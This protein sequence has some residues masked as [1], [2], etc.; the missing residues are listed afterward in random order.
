MIKSSTSNKDI[1]TPDKLDEDKIH[2]QSLRPVRFNDFVGQKKEID[3]LREKI[4]IMENEMTYTSH[5]IY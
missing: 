3:K 2:E 4:R 5:H 1:T